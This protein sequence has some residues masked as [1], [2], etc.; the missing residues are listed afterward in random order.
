MK[1]IREKLLILSITKWVYVFLFLNFLLMGLILGSLLS[2]EWVISST[3]SGGILRCNSGDCS[4]N[5]Y[6]KISCD[7]DCEYS[8]LETAGIVCIVFDLISLIT[9]L[10]WAT[11]LVYRTKG[12]DILKTWLRYTI[13]TG[14]MISHWIG[15]I[16]WGVTGI[17]F[18]GNGKHSGTG[19]A[20]AVSVAVIYPIVV[21]LYFLLFVKRQEPQHTPNMDSIRIEKRHKWSDPKSEEEYNKN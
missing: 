4:G 5:H 7:G 16:T 10:I 3:W 1:N 8:N 15:I 14:G 2:K 12:A 20:L 11:E 9:L 6:S 21:F 18:A 13:V 17:T 19:P